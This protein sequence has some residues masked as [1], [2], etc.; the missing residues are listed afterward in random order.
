MQTNNNHQK[1]NGKGKTVLYKYIWSLLRNKILSGQYQPGDKLP[2]EE[3]LALQYEVS[4]ITIRGALAGLE[5]ENL[6]VRI[7]A[8]GTFV[9][10]RIPVEKQF[11]VTGGVHDIVL[12]ASRYDVKALGIEKTT[13]G[14]LRN[15]NEIKQFFGYPEN[16][17]ITVVKRIRLLKNTPIFYIEN[18][19]P[20]E[21]AESL[22]MEELS[23]RPLLEIL[24]EKIDLTIGKGELFIE[25]MPA[26]PEVADFLNIQIF[27]SLVLLKLNYWFLSG[28]PIE[29]ANFFIRSDYFKY[30]VKLSGL[31]F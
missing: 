14:K 7:R 17:P 3:E 10:D 5:E 13:V 18:F 21:I 16:S 6:I 12:D 31:S 9:A 11:F 30:K 22:T 23:E 25:A 20:C 27:D 2:T 1:I 24:K 19:I 26:E 4:K 15:P 29:T 8:K 28:A